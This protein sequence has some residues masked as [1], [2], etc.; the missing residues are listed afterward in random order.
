MQKYLEY[1]FAFSLEEAIRS[2]K[3]FCT[4]GKFEG[5]GKFLGLESIADENTL[6]S[7]SCLE[8]ILIVC[9][10]YFVSPLLL[11]S[12][13]VFDILILSRLVLNYISSFLRLLCTP[14]QNFV[15]VWEV[16]P[17]KFSALIVFLSQLSAYLALSNMTD[18]ND[19]LL[20][21]WS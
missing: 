13:R 20:L 12:S 3:R 17:F 2:R 9:S 14:G 6:P 4:S 11:S 1:F 15:V 19:K 8:I 7:S 16:F 5:F 10:D 18:S 21:S